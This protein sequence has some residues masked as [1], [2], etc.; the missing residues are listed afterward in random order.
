VTFSLKVG[1][2]KQET[3]NK[4]ITQIPFAF[5]LLPFAFCLLPFA[6]CLLPFAFCLLPFAFCLLPFALLKRIFNAFELP[7]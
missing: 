4:R 3:G 6:F 7:L 5:C 2:G 1:N